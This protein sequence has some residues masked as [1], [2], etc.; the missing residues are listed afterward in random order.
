MPWGRM[1]C[2]AVN[3]RPHSYSTNNTLKHVSQNIVNVLFLVSGALDD[4][5]MA[6]RAPALLL[7]SGNATNNN[8]SATLKSNC[9]LEDYNTPP[10]S[11]GIHG[12]VESISESQSPIPTPS[13]PVPPPRTK[14]DKKAAAINL[15]SLHISPEP[16]QVRSTFTCIDLNFC[17][18]LLLLPYAFF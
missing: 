9:T 5:S 16:H 7:K 8:K 17:F 18:I 6:L 15:K 1:L 10:E 11:P 3:G 4:D 13:P 14:R 12:S 2:D